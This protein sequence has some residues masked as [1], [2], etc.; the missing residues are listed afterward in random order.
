MGICQ[1][2]ALKITVYNSEGQIEKYFFSMKKMRT[3]HT[4]ADVLISVNVGLDPRDKIYCK[5][6][7][8][9]EEVEAHSQ[10]Q[11]HDFV[12]KRGSKIVR[13]QIIME[14]MY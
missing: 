14:P 5:T 2:S 7:N 6:V 12:V 1:S 9:L 3:F 11:I 10:F 4:V 8:G 13:Y